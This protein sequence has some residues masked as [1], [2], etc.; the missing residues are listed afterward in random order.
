MIK[1]TE[2]KRGDVKTVTW[3]N[4]V[5]REEKFFLTKEETDTIIKLT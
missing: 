3:V 4:I 1:D 5:L 2:N